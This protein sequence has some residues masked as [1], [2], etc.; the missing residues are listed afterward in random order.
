MNGNNLRLVRGWNKPLH[1]PGPLA[2]IST[3]TANTQRDWHYPERAAQINSLHH[4]SDAL[5]HS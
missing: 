5:R 2:L 3:A 1:L 4:H